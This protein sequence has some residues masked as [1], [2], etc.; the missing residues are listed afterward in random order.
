MM[1][2][3]DLKSCE[4]CNPPNNT[5]V[6]CLLEDKVSENKKMRS[7]YYNKGVFWDNASSHAEGLECATYTYNDK[8][9]ECDVPTSD[10]KVIFW[11]KAD[12]NV[13]EVI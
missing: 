8:T 4:E 6:I 13:E 12:F 7:S 2:N 5:W 1:F 3:L 11:C 10:W 9:D